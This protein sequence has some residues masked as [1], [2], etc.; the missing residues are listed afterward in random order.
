M[1]KTTKDA[2]ITTDGLLLS[3]TG[4]FSRLVAQLIEQR[5]A[6]I[7]I[8]YQEM[9]V[10]GLLMGETNMTQKEL[11]A[12]L[13][14]RPATLSVALSRLEKSGLVKRVQSRTDKRVNYLKLIPSKKIAGVNA[15]LKDVE[16][17][18]TQGVS[19]TDLAKTRKVM[20]KLIQNLKLANEHEHST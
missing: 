20:D 16:N 19:A 7:G 10:A 13:L 8:T 4:Q 11:A 3:R 12:K 17:T 15:L 5:L 6:V 14:V 1:A 18:I 9:R 2:G